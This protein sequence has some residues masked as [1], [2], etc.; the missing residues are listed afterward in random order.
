MVEAVADK[1]ARVIEAVRALP[2]DSQETIVREMAERVSD[3]SE[4]HMTDT[5]RAEV[6]SRLA[7]PSRHVP[8]ARISDIL[9][10]SNPAL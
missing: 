4:S 5:Q 8:E 3:F 6:R 7:R 2:E 10:K 9:R 1:L